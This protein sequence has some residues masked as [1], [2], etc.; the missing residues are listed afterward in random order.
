MRAEGSPWGSDSGA[1]QSLLLLIGPDSDVGAI[2]CGLICS[3]Q[4]LQVIEPFPPGELV[5]RIA[6]P[7]LNRQES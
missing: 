7:S 5:R 3:L 6:V 1:D 2:L 4:I